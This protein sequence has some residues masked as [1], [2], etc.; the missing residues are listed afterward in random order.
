VTI[1]TGTRGHFRSEVAHDDSVPTQL[2]HP[3]SAV[4]VASFWEDPSPWRAHEIADSDI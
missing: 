1:P 4:A 2:P 3:Q